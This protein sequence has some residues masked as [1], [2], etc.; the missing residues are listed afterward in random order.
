MLHQ[1][2]IINRSEV[3]PA[4]DSYRRVRVLLQRSKLRAASRKER[5]QDH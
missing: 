4:A 5:F 3:S 2:V 1:G